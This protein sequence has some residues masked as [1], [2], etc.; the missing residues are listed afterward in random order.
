MTTFLRSS[1]DLSRSAT[2]TSPPTFLSLREIFCRLTFRRGSFLYGRP[3]D[4]G[5]NFIANSHFIRAIQN[6]RRTG[7]D[8]LVNQTVRELEI[9]Y[10]CYKLHVSYQEFCI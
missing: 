6:L 4:R 8:D 1:R 2:L 5:L 3:G 10:V 9:T 7:E